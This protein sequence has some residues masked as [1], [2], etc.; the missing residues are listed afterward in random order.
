VPLVTIEWTM[1][2]RGASH[3][4]SRTQIP[5][6]GAEAQTFHKAQGATFGPEYVVEVQMGIEPKYVMTGVDYVALSRTTGKENLVILLDTDAKGNK[7]ALSRDRFFRSKNKALC[8][9]WHD[10]RRQ[11]MREMQILQAKTVDRWLPVCVALGILS[12]GMDCAVGMAG[13]ASAADEI[14]LIGRDALAL[15]PSPVVGRVLLG[16]QCRATLVDHSSD[17]EA[18]L[19]FEDDLSAGGDGTDV[20][21]G[22]GGRDALVGCCETAKEA[23]SA[24]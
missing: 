5:L 19:G 6:T 24:G 14:R 2:T 16:S 4:C 12:P 10:E 15:G 17:F 9:L 21:D 1:Y 20:C 11:F 22:A 13:Y 3:F 8:A 7:V 18:D 23:V